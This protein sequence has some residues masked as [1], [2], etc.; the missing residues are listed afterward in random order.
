MRNPRV[1]FQ[2]FVQNVRDKFHHQLPPD[3]SDLPPDLPLEYVNH[4]LFPDNAGETRARIIKTL[5]S[6]REEAWRTRG[7]LWD[8]IA[9]MLHHLATEANPAPYPKAL[10]DF[11]DPNIETFMF[12]ITH[13][14]EKCTLEVRREGNDVLVSQV[15]NLC[16]NTAKGLHSAGCSNLGNLLQENV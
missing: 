14:I 1:L 8:Y 16:Y 7:K 5:P 4:P 6:S 10:D 13:N 11:F 2:D 12:S 15:Q 9:T 3:D